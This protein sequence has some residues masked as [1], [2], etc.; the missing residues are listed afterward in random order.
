[1]SGVVWAKDAGSCQASST[2]AFESPQ[3][4]GSTF[5]SF[6]I[7]D[8]DEYRCVFVWVVLVDDGTF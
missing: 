7:G 8:D 6:G 1:M 2:V 5:S 4:F 3:I